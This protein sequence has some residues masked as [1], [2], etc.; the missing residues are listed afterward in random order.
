MTP[1][2]LAQSLLQALQQLA[3]DQSTAAGITQ[4]L[5]AAMPTVANL[6]AQAGPAN[7]AIVADQQNVSNLWTQFVAAMTVAGFP[8][9]AT[10]PPPATRRRPAP[11]PRR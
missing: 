7:Q 8:V 11:W 6:L 2:Q 5:A 1:Q 10:P 9:P 4:Q 3:G